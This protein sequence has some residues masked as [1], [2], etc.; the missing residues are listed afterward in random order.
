ML[1]SPLCAAR[2]FVLALATA[3]A[4]EP[5]KPVPKAPPANRPI[6]PSK[7]PANA[8]IIVSDNPRDAHDN[9]NGI[10]LSPEEYKK[11][12]DSAERLKQLVSDKPEPP[13]VCRISGRFETRGTQEVAALRAEFQFRTTAVRSTVLLGLQKGK[14]VAATIDDGK[15]AVLVPLAEGDGFAVLVDSAGEHR[16]VVDL[17][18]P[19]ISRGTKG[20]ERGV[21][22]GLPGAAITA[23]ERLEM[24]KGVTKVRLAG[25]TL[26]ARQLAGGTEKAP[27]A[28]LGPTPKLD[29]S[30]DASPANAKTDARSSVEGR[31]DVRVEDRALVTRGKLTLKVQ[32]GSVGR[33]EISA[34]LS[35]DLSADV[36]NGV[37]STVRIEKPRERTKPWIIRRDVSADDLVLDFSFRIE[38]SI[39]KT[40]GVQ[41]C[42]VAGAPQRGTITVGGPLHL[43]LTYKP[44]ADVVR[45]KQRMT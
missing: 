30:W 2:H 34:P 5:A 7:L 45:R 15:L 1:H 24:P 8:V 21:E 11:L 16:V 31:Y 38:S 17:E 14:P 27:A 18:V 25:R 40:V 26:S 29:L 36:A 6:D 32:S 43:R 37:D 42:G 19:L 28:L 23:I 13:S 39:G 20:S 9:V 35:A 10:V 12:L 4:D 3:C 22:L 41:L 33:W 44:A